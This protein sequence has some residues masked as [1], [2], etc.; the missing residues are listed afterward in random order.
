MVE[1]RVGQHHQVDGSGIH[2]RRSP[3]SQAQLFQT[4]EQTAVNQNP[5]PLVLNQE[6][7][8]SD[9]AGRPQE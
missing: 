3:V 1:V 5:G 8:A 6:A 4:L 9:R 7:R 2:R